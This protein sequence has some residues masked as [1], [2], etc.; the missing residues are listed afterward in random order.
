MSAILANATGF[1]LTTDYPIDQVVY[2]KQEAYSI[3]AGSNISIPHGLPFTPLPMLQWSFNSNFSVLYESNTGPFPSGNLDYLFSLQISIEANATNIVIRGN[4]VTAPTTVYVRILC[5]APSDDTSTV[6]ATVS[7]G[8]NFVV[9]LDDNYMK[10]ITANKVTVAASSSAV[11]PHSLGVIPHIL[12]WMASNTGTV[13]PVDL[14]YP[15]DNANIEATSSN[16]TIRNDDFLGAWT[17][18]YRIYHNA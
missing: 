15:R 9:N 1:L 7:L 5:V 17:I 14:A 12:A 16:L 8:D 13:Y 6:A 18:H 11:V 2:I 3:G 10:L 4:G